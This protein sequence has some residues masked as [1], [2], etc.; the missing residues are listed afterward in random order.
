MNNFRKTAGLL[1]MVL[2]AALLAAGCSKKDKRH[3]NQIRN[4]MPH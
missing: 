3:R 2:A 4:G 1:L